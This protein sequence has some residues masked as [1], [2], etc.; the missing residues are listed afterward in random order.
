MDKTPKVTI[1][2]PTFQQ[3][4]YVVRAV[5]SALSQDYRNLEVVVCDDSRDDQTKE[6]LLPILNKNQRLIYIK[7]PVQLGR[8]ANYRNALYHHASGEWVLTLDGDDYLIDSSFITD[9]M[10]GIQMDREIVWVLG[11]GEIRQEESNERS[12]LLS[13]RIPHVRSSTNS[14]IIQGIDYMKWF[15]YHR[16]FLHLCALF[17][18]K[19]A[20]SIDFYRCDLLSSD[21]ESFMRLALHGKL[22]LIKRVVGVWWQHSENAGQKASEDEILYNSRWAISVAMYGIEHKFLK[23]KSASTWAKK[24]INSE[25]I[26]VFNREMIKAKMI[27]KSRKDRLKYTIKFLKKNPALWYNAIFFKKMLYGLL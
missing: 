5:T 19:T 10:N 8:A 9:A 6:A 17:H 22:F 2:V 23:E 4:K 16:G 11:G 20:L 15:P 21:L 3:H 24:V 27:G 1:I 18:R 13:T 25:A 26:G 14:D 12:S 7:N